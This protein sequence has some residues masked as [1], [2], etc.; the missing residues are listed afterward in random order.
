MTTRSSRPTIAAVRAKH[1]Q[2]I[3]II[4]KAIHGIAVVNREIAGDASRQSI[5]QSRIF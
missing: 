2:T 5:E 4:R 1:L 3:L